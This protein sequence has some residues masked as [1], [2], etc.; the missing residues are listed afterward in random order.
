MVIVTIMIAATIMNEEEEVV[1]HR[2]GLAAIMVVVAK[3]VEAVVE[4]IKVAIALI[5]TT[6]AQFM[7]DINGESV[8]STLTV[9]II[10]RGQAIKEIQIP[11][12]EEMARGAETLIILMMGIT[13]G[14]TARHLTTTIIIQVAGQATVAVMI[15]VAP[16][17][18]IM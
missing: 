16:R 4:E 11:R 12:V 7:V 1:M 9:I 15:A 2:A 8:F 14:E 17:Q 10:G 18:A 5:T 6:L 13:A 3:V